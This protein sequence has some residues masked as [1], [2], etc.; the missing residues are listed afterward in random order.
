MKKLMSFGEAMIDFVPTTNG[1][2]LHEVSE[3]RRAPGG[4][5]ANVAVAVARLGGESHFVGKIGDD[6]FGRFL[7]GVFKEHGVQ[8]DY[9]LYTREAKT[10]LA[11]VSLR[12]DGE[13]DFMFYREPSADMLFEADE[14]NPAWF[15]SPGIFHFCSVSLSYPVSAAATRRGAELAYQKN[16]LVSFDPNL[17][18]PLWKR[19]GD[20][21]EAV[22]P[23]LPFANVVKVA[24]D[25]LLFLTQ[26]REQARAA[27]SL[28]DLGVDLVVVTRGREGCGYYT[29]QH[30]GIV[31][32][33]PVTA[34]DATGAGDGFDGGL[35]YRLAERDLDRAGFRRFLQDTGAL[36]AVLRF[37]NGCGAL[38]TT[39]RGAIP[40]LPTREAV[41]A[42]LGDGGGTTA[43]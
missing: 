10:A 20:A 33:V 21:R 11:F 42:L 34:V 7:A 17:R 15:Q 35:L 24:E 19:P 18:F 37:A 6:A 13:R 43:G 25:E 39:G 14:M 22:L 16:W 23:L 1:Q 30:S 8:T 32:T 3:F 27:Q 26:A 29:K 4:A 5:P 40:A 12:E 41:E 2:P 31:P 36:E 9:L 38:T 28:I